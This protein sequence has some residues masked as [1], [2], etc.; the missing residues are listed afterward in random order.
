M[1]KL[2]CPACGHKIRITR[3][4]LG[5]GRADCYRCRTSKRVLPHGDGYIISKYVYPAYT[6]DGRYRGPVLVDYIITD[7]K[8]PTILGNSVGLV[9]H[10]T[11]EEVTA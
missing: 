11:K 2:I 7:T 4:P 3:Y 9:R 6:I 5:G 8:L 1:E 10:S